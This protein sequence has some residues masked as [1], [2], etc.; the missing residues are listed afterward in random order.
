LEAGRVLRAYFSR[1]LVP[2]INLAVTTPHPIGMCTKETGT[3]R[4]VHVWET[5][6]SLNAIGLKECEMEA[7]ER[8]DF[9]IGLFI[10]ILIILASSLSRLGVAPKIIG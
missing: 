1:S 4:R 6:Y 10:V 9:D 2:V 5:P 7:A 3:L 8:S